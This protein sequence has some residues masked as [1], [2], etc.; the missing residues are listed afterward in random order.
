MLIAA[1]TS[2][3]KIP[4]LK[5]RFS[6]GKLQVFVCRDNTCSLPVNSF[7]ETLQLLNQ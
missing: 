2:N 6:E 7:V 4:L 3:S 5:D 1:S